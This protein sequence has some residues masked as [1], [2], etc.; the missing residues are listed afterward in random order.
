MRQKDTIFIFISKYLFRKN[1]DAKAKAQV[2]SSLYIW[3]TV[4]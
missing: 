2:N 4:N 3:I 1:K